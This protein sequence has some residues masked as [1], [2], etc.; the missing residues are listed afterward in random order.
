[1]TGLVASSDLVVQSVS[2][3]PIFAMERRRWSTP[4]VAFGIPIVDGTGVKRAM[5]VGLHTSAD[6]HSLSGSLN[7]GYVN[8]WMVSGT[9]LM[10]GR[11]FVN[12][13]NCSFVNCIKGNLSHIKVRAAQIDLFYDGC[14]GHET[15]S[16]ILQT[17]PR[18]HQPQNDRHNR[19]NK[20]LTALWVSWVSPCAWSRG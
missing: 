14:R 16:H 7:T 6:G 9:A 19:I 2:Q 13:I 11:S 8:Q 4:L 18:T 17:C 1:M 12:C 5:A 3:M 20:Y 10:T 15:L